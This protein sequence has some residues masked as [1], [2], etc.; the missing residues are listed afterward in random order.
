MAA[1][2]KTGP[3]KMMILGL[4][5]SRSAVAGGV[6]LNYLMAGHDP[7][8]STC[9]WKRIE[10]SSDLFSR[11]SVSGKSCAKNPGSKLCNQFVTYLTKL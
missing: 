6:K 8:V 2:S 5:Y 10:T 3:M 4:E 7:A 1:T 9:P 11:E